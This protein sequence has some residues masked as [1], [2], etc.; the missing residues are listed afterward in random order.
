[1]R[2]H[3]E[4][5][6]GGLDGQPMTPM[7]TGAGGERVSLVP[8]AQTEDSA[9]HEHEGASGPGATAAGSCDPFPRFPSTR[10]RRALSAASTILGVFCMALA[11][12]HMS[13]PDPSLPHFPSYCKNTGGCARIALQNPC[14]NE[15]LAP[16]RF[17]VEISWVR[18]VVGYSVINIREGRCRNYKEA[19][20]CRPGPNKS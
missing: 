19:P 2:P 13:S 5:G 20:G 8:P 14:R 15:S 1:V 3:L 16:L 9:A 6:S 11:A 18:H 4:G 7:A 17:Q 10:T 12:I